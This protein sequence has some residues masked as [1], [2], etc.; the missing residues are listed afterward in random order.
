MKQNLL[1][2]LNSSPQILHPSPPPTTPPPHSLSQTISTTHHLHHTD[3]SPCSKLS[4]HDLTISRP[5]LS[6]LLVAYA[7]VDPFQFSKARA[8]AIDAKDENLN[9][10]GC[11]NKILTKRAFFDVSIDGE[12]AGRIVVG[13]Y[14]LTRLQAPPG[15]ATW[16]AGPRAS[17]TGGRSS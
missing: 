7:N 8:D 16:L 2:A 17:A 6:L 3:T 13:L 12:P 14:G 5:S 15:S 4:R 1:K 10:N 11:T 9:T